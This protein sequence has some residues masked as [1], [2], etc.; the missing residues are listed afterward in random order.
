MKSNLSTQELVSRNRK[1]VGVLMIVIGVISMIIGVV[2]D[3]SSF[4]GGGIA[5]VIIGFT[6]FIFPA[7]MSKK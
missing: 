3:N 2:I 5:P 7:L 6:A 4:I 1:I